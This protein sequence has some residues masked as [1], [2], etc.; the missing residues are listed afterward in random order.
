MAWL[1]SIYDKIPGLHNVVYPKPQ[2]QFLRES[3]DHKSILKR[4][5]TSTCMTKI[6]GISIMSS[7]QAKPWKNLL[8]NT[9]AF[10][11]LQDPCEACTQ[12][13]RRYPPPDETYQFVIKSHRKSGRKPIK[14]TKQRPSEENIIFI[15]HLT[16]HCGTVCGLIKRDI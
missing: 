4:K 9:R 2:N 12:A 6:P 11:E 15:R 10:P 3:Q 14:K 8:Q 16:V 13:K 7:Q 1:E 5:K